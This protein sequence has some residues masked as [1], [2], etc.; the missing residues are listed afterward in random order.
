MTPRE[1]AEHVEREA[2]RMA[3][4]LDDIKAR[5][6]GSVVAERIRTL[7]ATTAELSRLA[8]QHAIEQERQS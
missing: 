5:N 6:H 3:W 4:T 1:F 2:D 7:E 8:R